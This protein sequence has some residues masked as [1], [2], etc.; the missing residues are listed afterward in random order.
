MAFKLT[1][2]QQEA[3]KVLSGPEGTIMLYGGA[4]SAKTFVLIYALIVRAMR[5][6]GSR[7]IV[8]R[9]QFSAVKNSIV[10]DTFPK[11][12]ELAFPD[13]VPYSYVNRRD[14]KCIFPN[15]SE[16]H[17]AGLDTKLKSEKI[18]GREF[19]TMYFNEASEI[20]YEAFTMAAS[21][22]LAQKTLLRLKTYVDE[23][24]P[25]KGHW[26]YKL[27]IEHNEPKSG[28]AIRKDR[29]ASLAMNPV[30]NVDN[31][32]PEF[33]EQLESLPEEERNRFLLGLFGDTVSGGVYN[34]EL[35]RLLTEGYLEENLQTDPNAGL[36]LVFD[37]GHYDSTAMWV[38]QFLPGRMLFVD[39]VEKNF[40]TMPYFIA[41]AIRR[42][43]NYTNIFLP[44]DADNISWGTGRSIR[45]SAIAIA[46]RT[47]GARVQVLQRLSLQD[48]IH[49]ARLLLHN[50][51]RFDK[52]NC[53]KGLDALRNYH[54]EFDFSSGT[55]SEQPVHD[56]SSHAADAF[57][58]ACMA[59]NHSIKPEGLDVEPEKKGFTFN[60]IMPESVK[61]EEFE[62]DNSI[63]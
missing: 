51:V 49:G 53:K 26:T 57:R 17:F 1:A 46:K 43:W 35:E 32:P 22:R 33:M 63:G 12:I 52:N 41:E 16:I 50:S 19:A 44:H 3:L 14:W 45:E 29:H 11:V 18:L 28:K 47:G 4:R 39:Y 40:E 10:F 7:H 42:G 2:K 61:D 24:P 21:T 62:E 54:Y 31:L 20:N 27:F 59:Y 60:D 8:L 37:I 34:K 23:N 6:P 58:Y 38:V 5:A 56:W 36:S 13:L 30:D 25:N 9:H 55:Y 15:K 48:T